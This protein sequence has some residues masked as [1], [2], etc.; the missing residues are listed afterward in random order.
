MLTIAWKTMI[1]YSYTGRRQ[2]RSRDCPLEEWKILRY[3]VYACV[4]WEGKSFEIY[5]YS[6]NRTYIKIML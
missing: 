3:E 4:S 5:D 6:T 1:S 2:S